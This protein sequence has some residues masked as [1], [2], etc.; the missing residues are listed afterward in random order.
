MLG[1]V[2]QEFIMQAEYRTLS[3]S[4]SR[5]SNVD[6]SLLRAKCYPTELLHLRRKSSNE[7]SRDRT[8]ASLETLQA[9]NVDTIN[10]SRVH[11]RRIRANRAQNEGPDNE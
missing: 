1:M 6:P 2:K 10:E 9:S 8:P 5:E 3:R 7:L 4:S 11:T